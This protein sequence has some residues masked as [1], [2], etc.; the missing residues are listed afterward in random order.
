MKNFTCKISEEFRPLVGLITKEFQRIGFVLVNNIQTCCDK[1]KVLYPNHE[2]FAKL[3]DSFEG[4]T[5]TQ[6]EF[7]EYY[8]REKDVQYL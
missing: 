4:L 7:S 6:N 3:R 8:S 2:E 5:L 1:W